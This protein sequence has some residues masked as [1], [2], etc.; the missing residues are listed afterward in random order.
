MRRAI[1][2]LFDDRDFHG[3][4]FL[5]FVLPRRTECGHTSGVLVFAGMKGNPFG[6]FLFNHV[7]FFEGEVS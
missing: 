6:G 3:A 7:A 5:L 4:S 1:H 2:C